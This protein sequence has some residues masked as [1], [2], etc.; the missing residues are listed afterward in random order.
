LSKEQRKSFEE[1]GFWIANNNYTDYQ[2]IQ[3]HKSLKIEKMKGGTRKITFLK[4]VPL[5]I[6]FNTYKKTDEIYLLDKCTKLLP[7]NKC[8]IFRGRPQICRKARCIVFDKSPEIQFY[9]ENGILK[10]KI[11]AYKKGELKKW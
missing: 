10:D 5:T 1:Q 9:A 3:Y 6:I 4:N 2:W 11:E 8:K 7:D